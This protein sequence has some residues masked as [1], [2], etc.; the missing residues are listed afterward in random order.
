[1]IQPEPYLITEEKFDLYSDQLSFKDYFQTFSTLIE[2]SRKWPARNGSSKLQDKGNIKSKLKRSHSSLDCANTHVEDELE[3]KSLAM[4]GKRSRLEDSII[5]PREQKRESDIFENVNEKEKWTS[6]SH[7][8]PKKTH[9]HELLPQPRFTSIG[10]RNLKFYKWYSKVK[11]K[12]NQLTKSDT[13]KIKFTVSFSF[14]ENFIDFHKKLKDSK[15]FIKLMNN[16]NISDY[17]LL[18]WVLHCF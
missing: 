10:P 8:Q 18:F 14:C 4:Q 5:S 3:G 2:S 11:L 6:I 7:L 17:I 1:M 12:R 13:N 16:I 9:Y 15:K